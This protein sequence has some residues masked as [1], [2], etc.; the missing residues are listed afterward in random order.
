MDN[1]GARRIIPIILVLIVIAVAIA[2]VV[3]IGQNIFGGGDSAEEVNQGQ[4]SLLDTS[5][6]RAVRMTVRGPIVA[7]EQ[8]ATFTITVKP[9]SRNMTTYLGYLSQQ[10]ETVNKDNNIPAYEQLVYALDRNNMMDASVPEDSNRND[11]RGIC[12]TGRMFTFETLNNNTVIKSL[13]TTTCNDA[14]G[15]LNT[16]YA[17]LQNLFLRQI[18]TSNEMI[19]RMTVAAQKAK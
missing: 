6:S 16:A 8:F 10:L 4:R 13:W 2:A 5:E 1:G 19:N 15:T 3:S 9:N 11:T 14:R 7:N 12:P 18:P 17:P